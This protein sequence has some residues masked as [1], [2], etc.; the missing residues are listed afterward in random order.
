MRKTLNQKIRR[1]EKDF[2][3]EKLFENVVLIFNRINSRHKQG[4]AKESTWYVCLHLRYILL[5]SKTSPDFKF[6]VAELKGQLHPSGSLFS[7]HD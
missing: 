7:G 3:E 6:K 5:G 4:S 2:D 1:L